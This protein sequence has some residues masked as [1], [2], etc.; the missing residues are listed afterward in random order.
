M[1]KNLVFDVSVFF[2]FD[3]GKILA[4]LGF[5]S[6]EILHLKR[7]VFNQKLWRDMNDGKILLETFRNEVCKLY[8]QYK[9]EFGEIFNPEN[10]STYMPQIKENI[11]LTSKA[12]ENGY[13]VYIL[14]NS[15]YDIITYVMNSLPIKSKISGTMF[16]CVENISMPNEKL[17]IMFLEKFNLNANDCLFVDDK[18]RYLKAAK[19]LGFNTLLYQYN[20][21]GQSELNNILLQKIV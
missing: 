8:P 13:K 12:V 4:R 6:E 7:T 5:S 3:I 9:K 17:F 20:K 15:C 1:V 18:E 16:S 11:L 21:K 19:K 14:T 2:D 10:L